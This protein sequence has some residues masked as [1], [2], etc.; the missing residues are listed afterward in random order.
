M[1]SR[2][3]ERYTVIVSERIGILEPKNNKVLEIQNWPD[4]DSAEMGC[5]VDQWLVSLRKEGINRRQLERV[6]R[7]L[8]KA[9]EQGWKGNTKVEQASMTSFTAWLLESGR[10]V[11]GGKMPI[12]S[13]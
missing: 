6:A 8:A 2:R 11:D 7:A 10:Y 1:L 12:P 5:L 13:L 3:V 4:P 9:T